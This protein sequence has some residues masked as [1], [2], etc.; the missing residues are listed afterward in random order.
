MKQILDK[1][2]MKFTDFLNKGGGYVV[3]LV[4]VIAIVFAIV[5]FYGKNGFDWRWFVFFHLPLYAFC[6]WALY[7]TVKTY[8]KVINKERK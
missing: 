2:Y 3:I 4:G 1:F 5:G 6:G 8:N 7:Q